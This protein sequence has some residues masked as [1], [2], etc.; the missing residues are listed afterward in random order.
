VVLLAGAGVGGGSLNYANTLYVPPSPF[1]QDPQWRDITD[2]QDELAPHYRMA[3][4]MLGVV[5][6]PCEGAI[7]DVMRK[8]AADLGVADTF[9]KTPV[10]V[11]FGRPG[12]RVTDPYF[13]GAGPERTGCTECGNCMV[14]CRVGAKNTLVKNYLALAEGRGATIEPLRTVVRVRPVGGQAAYEVSSE[15][16]GAWL[17]KD[18]RAVTAR[19]VVFA[20]GAWGTQKLLHAMRDSGDLPALSPRLGHVTRTNSE[21]LN[22]V[23]LERVPPGADLTRGVAITSSFHPDADT[24]VENVR[25]GKGSN[26]MG[27]LGTIMVP[28]DRLP[29]PLQ[30]LLEA[31]RHPVGFARSMSQYRWSERTVIGLVMQTRDNSLHVSGRRGLFGGRTLTSRQGHGEPNPTFIPSGQRAMTTLARVLSERTGV[32][33][34]PGSSLGEILNVPMTAHFLGGV[35]I[36]D[37]PERGVIDPY[38]RVWGYPGLHV[39]D[40]SA[41]SANLGVNPSLTIT[42]QAERAMSLWPNA[43]DQDPRPAQGEA[44]QRLAPVSARRPV[45]RSFTAAP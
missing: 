24:H 32:R 40:G 42:A 2:W 39:V 44:Y 30:F 3:S 41:V 8:A 37:E 4:R 19:H 5:T 26:A 38:H 11:Y 15:R 17:R 45:V 6:N 28:G 16:T 20:A 23:M 34:F 14:G 18:R 25:Y 43:G 1:F 35:V 21:A 31:A 13:G 27:V 7:E 29:R 12:E 36:G 33:A 10:G 22:G 9:R